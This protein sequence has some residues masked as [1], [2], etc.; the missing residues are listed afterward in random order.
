MPFPSKIVD[1]AEVRT[2]ILEGKP[3][4]E[5]ADIYQQRY[6]AGVPGY[7]IVTEHTARTGQYIAPS[8][9]SNFRAEH[10]LPYRYGIDDKTKLEYKPWKVRKEHQGNGADVHVNYLIRIKTGKP[11][12]ENRAKSTH[13][14]W[15]ELQDQDLVLDYSPTVGY[16]AVPRRH[17]VDGQYI[18]NTQVE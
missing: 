14:F 9:F 1:R 18:R 2:W 16:F 11:V 17:G 10:N 4:R 15:R 3:Y 12:P 8:T 5:M 6:E 13:H 7:D